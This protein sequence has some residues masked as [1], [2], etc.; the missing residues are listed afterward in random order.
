MA[1]NSNIQNLKIAAEDY[2]HVRRALGF[3]LVRAEYLLSQFIDF[4][5]RE[6][7]KYITTA[8]AIRWATKN[9]SC[10]PGR[11]AHR[12]NLVR[13]FARF[14][15]VADPRTEVPPVG[16]LTQRYR[17]KPR[18][19]PS[20]RDVMKLLAAAKKVRSPKGLWNTTHYTLL[21]LLAATGMRVG[22]VVALNRND[23]NLRSGIITI[24]N[25]KFGKSRAVPIHH[26]T[27][28]ALRAYERL[29]DS[30]VPLSENQSFFVS[31]RGARMTAKFVGKKYIVLAR[32]AGIRSPK[33]RAGP[34]LHDLRHRFAI[35]TMLA[36]YRNGVDV[37]QKM[38]VLST[39][40]GHTN[41]AHTYWYLSSVPELLSLAVE[42]LN[43]DVEGVA[44]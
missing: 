35:R 43:T 9:V 14:R 31:E 12:L 8:L 17:R 30:V 18:D 40:L 27:V 24:R 4:L 5:K 32:Q 37:E 16:I 21:G 42:R 22:E 6:K 15:K 33:G 11:W 39:Y 41:T 20:D 38:P 44:S 7:A 34:R 29:R 2:L 36:W 28:K 23:V 19:I 25:A 3:K 26:S 1:R 10:H 13:C